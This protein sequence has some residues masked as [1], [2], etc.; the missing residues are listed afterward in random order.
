MADSQKNENEYQLGFYCTSELFK[1]IQ[2]IIQNEGADLKFKFLL[3]GSSGSTF[4]DDIN[5]SDKYD[6]RQTRELFRYTT[7]KILKR[8]YGNFFNNDN[9]MTYKTLDEIGAWR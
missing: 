1:R 8:R 6:I 2:E 9:E 5:C 7:N 3:A 4:Y